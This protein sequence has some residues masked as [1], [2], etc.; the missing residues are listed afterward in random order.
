VNIMET[1]TGVIGMVGKAK[2]LADKLKNLELKEVIVD[3][4]GKVLGLKEEI[5][6]LREENAQLKEQVKRASAPPEVTVKNGMYYKD[7]DGPFCTACY[8]S[9]GK[10][11]RLI[12][13]A[14]DERMMGIHRKCQACQAT[15]SD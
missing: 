14:Q 6:K 10:L 13:G 9:R 7:D 15:Y 4:Q 5:V 11:T 3:L 8:D 12:H 1:I 2:E